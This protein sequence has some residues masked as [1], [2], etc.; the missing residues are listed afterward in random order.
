MSLEETEDAGA[1]GS[2]LD[3]FM[4][5]GVVNLSANGLART[6]VAGLRSLLLDFALASL[7]LFEVEAGTAR[8]G[9]SSSDEEEDSLLSPDSES[10]ELD[11]SWGAV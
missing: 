1:E 9:F 7:L 10:D 5:V 4:P 8:P 6:G 11:D 3:A 2:V